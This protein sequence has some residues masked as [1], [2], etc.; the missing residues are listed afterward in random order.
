MTEAIRSWRRERRYRVAM[1]ALNA[2]SSRELRALGISRTQIPRLA[3]EA[4]RF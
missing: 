1:Q 3:K 4:A 2:L